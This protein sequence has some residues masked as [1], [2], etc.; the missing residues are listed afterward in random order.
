MTEFETRVRDKRA[1]ARTARLMEIDLARA[2]VMS[3]HTTMLAQQSEITRDANMNGVDSHN[4]GTGARRNERAT[5][6]CT[7]PDFMKCQPLNYKGTEG[8]VE[9][10]RWFEI[11]ETVISISNC[12]LENQILFSTCTLLA[13]ALTWWNSYVSTVGHDVTYAMTWTDLK[14]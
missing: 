5:R 2:E 7:Y 13:G 1:H 12:S 14:K 11:M 4:S 10:I 6:E 8:V 3:L 9:L